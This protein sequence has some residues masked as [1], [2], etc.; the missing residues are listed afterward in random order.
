MFDRFG[1]LSEKKRPTPVLGGQ[2][3][4][5]WDANKC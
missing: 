4:T 3:Q 5:G 1:L 2:Y